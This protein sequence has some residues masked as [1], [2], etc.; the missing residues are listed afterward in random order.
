LFFD[1][2]QFLR[3]DERIRNFPKRP[4]RAL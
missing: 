2:G 1:G 3:S 4:Q